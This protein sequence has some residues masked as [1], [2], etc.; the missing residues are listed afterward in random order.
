MSFRILEQSP[1]YFNSQG[2]PCAGGSLTFYASGTTTPK[3]VYGD[4]VLTV[5]NGSV[6]TLD[7]SG[8]V[9]VGDVWGSGNYT[10]ILKDS[11]GNVIPG[12]SQDNVKD[13]STVIPAGTTGQLLA[14]DSG[15]NLIALTAILVPDPTG[16]V[17]KVLTVTA[18]PTVAW[19]VPSL[20][21]GAS[22]AFTDW[23]MNNVRGKL[24]VTAAT[25]TLTIDWKVAPGVLLT[26]GTDCALTFT[27]LPAAGEFAIL[28]IIRI[29]DATGTS[30]ALT[31]AASP[32]WPA[33][34]AVPL[35]QTTGAID[36]ISFLGY[37]GVATVLGS[38]NTAFG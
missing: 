10:V 35:T 12:G 2:I 36:V 5:N 13:P 9:Q 17:G 34:T 31:Y 11:G 20:A 8:R 18:G 28:T 30:R 37:N 29:K 24:S 14:Y 23:V 6:L 1:V 19:G 32:K 4:P 25:T 27:N 26:H 22:A 7:S 33:S 15:G 38:Y 3:N 16:S 21:T